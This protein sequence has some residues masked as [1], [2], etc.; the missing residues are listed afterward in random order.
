VLFSVEVIDFYFEV[1]HLDSPLLFISE[2]VSMFRNFHV[3]PLMSNGVAIF[4]TAH[5]DTSRIFQASN[6]TADTANGLKSTFLASM[7]H[8]LRT[9]LNG[10]L[11]YTQILR[12][13]TALTD[14]QSDGL[15]IIHQSADHLLAVINDVLDLAKIE[16]RKLELHRTEFDLHEFVDGVQA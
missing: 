5:R 6:D 9:P 12:R 15:T 11:G 14:K 1:M 3:E 8:E 7:S 2:S 4:V 13:D 10:I 16:A